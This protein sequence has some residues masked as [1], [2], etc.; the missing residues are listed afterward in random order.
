[1]KKTAM[2]LAVTAA[3]LGG[4]VSAYGSMYTN[5]RGLGEAMV[6]PFYSSANGNDTY[7]HVVN[8][9][10]YTKAV[11]VR[12][13]E[14]RNSTEVLD[15]NLYLSPY[16]EWAG[17]ITRNTAE[18]STGAIIRTVD[19]SCTVPEL[20]TAGGANVGELAGT[21][22][23]LPNGKILRDQPFVNFKYLDD[24]E[25]NENAETGLVRTTEGY[26]EVIEMGQLS[27]NLGLGADA[28]HGSD[29]VPADCD[30]LV[31]AW[32]TTG[33]QQGIWAADAQAELLQNTGL[34]WVGGGLYGYGV[35]INVENGTAAGYDAVAIEGF[36][37]PEAPAPLHFPPGLERPSLED[38]NQE[39]VIFSDGAATE[40]FFGN[41]QD[42]ASALFST[43]GIANDYVVDPD[44]DA[45]T[46]WVITMP[47]KRSYT[48]GDPD[49]DA[50]RPFK[51]GR[52]SC[53]ERV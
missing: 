40:Y 6:Y 26:I 4:A 44:I 10:E 5:D 46:D 43:S 11:K 42:A 32:T 39:V 52:A 35:L 20:G 17:V 1:M 48:Q 34:G 19:N 21:Q 31:A 49:V 30:A 23:T 13:V 53:R 33:G 37:D 47:T 36:N 8:T 18:G 50:I 27:P 28:V 2:S 9:T 24:A 51:I 14:A 45:L 3:L 16:D 25:R 15:F 12:F 38:A 41:G 22:T 7:V 29:G